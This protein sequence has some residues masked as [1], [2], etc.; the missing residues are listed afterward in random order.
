MKHNYALGWACNLNDLFVRFPY[1]KCKNL[2]KKYKTKH[3]QRQKI[4]QVFRTGVEIILND[5]IENNASFQIPSLKYHGGEIHYEPIKGSEFKRLREKGKFDRID[6]LETLFTGYQ[7]YL[8][9]HGK[10]DN[11]L[12]RRKIPIYISSHYKR[13]MEDLVNKGKTY[14]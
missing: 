10:N 13:K 1:E 11:F 2:I 12:A 9:L 3:L 8:Y 6:F 5:I 7:L 4:K 14:C